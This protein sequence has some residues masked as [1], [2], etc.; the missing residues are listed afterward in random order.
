[1][2]AKQPLEEEEVGLFEAVSGSFGLVKLVWGWCGL[3]WFHGR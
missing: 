3:A 1:M 2:P